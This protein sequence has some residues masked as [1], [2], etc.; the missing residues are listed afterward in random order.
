MNRASITNRRAA[1]APAKAED[2]QR[3][4]VDEKCSM[5]SADW[6]SYWNNEGRD[7]CC[8]RHKATLDSRVSEDIA[9][10]VPEGGAVLDY[11]CGRNGFIEDLIHKAD[12]L[13][14][15]DAAVSVREE[16]NRRFDNHERIMV[17][18]PE[19]LALFPDGAFGLIVMHSVAQY[20]SVAE[21]QS[22]LVTI[23][24]LMKENGRLLLGDIVP[25]DN[26]AF[27]DTYAF[28]QFWSREG[29][30]LSAA[31]CLF[32]MMFSPYT[33]VRIGVGLQ[34]YDDATL[35]DMLRSSG[36]ICD[37]LARNIG[38][39]QTRLS[40]LCRKRPEVKRNVADLEMVRPSVV[41]LVP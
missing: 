21:L 19:E 14:L 3:V 17:L 39:N 26:S 13:I 28:L 41:R 7:G 16:M 4:S 30:A 8:H 1:C 12:Q 24:R 18:S 36:L 25:T 40:Y 11:G 37:R 15:C 32:R 23:E 2:I 29:G 38:H 9:R 6:I 20:L 27:S 31:Y 33:K 34:T 35:L 10:Y 22:A 5:N